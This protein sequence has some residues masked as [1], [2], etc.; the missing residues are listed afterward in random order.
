M[1]QRLL[2]DNFFIY[3]K[4]LGQL[5][6]LVSC[7]RLFKRV[8]LSQALGAGEALLPESLPREGL[9]VCADAYPEGTSKNTGGCPASRV[10]DKRQ[11]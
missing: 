5:I 9:G 2:F 11:L 1:K 3:L 8:A 7:H 4:V 6:K 10:L